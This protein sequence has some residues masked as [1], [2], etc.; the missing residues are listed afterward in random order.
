MLARCA[1]VPDVRKIA[2]LRVNALGDLIFSLPALEALR[3]AY[4]MAEIVLLA[5]DWHATFLTGRP[6]PVDRVVVVPPSTGV[7]GPPGIEVEEDP[8]ELE[9]FFAAMN[10]ERFDLAIQIHGGG[11]YSNPFVQRLGAKLA[12]GLRTPDAAPLDRWVPYIYYQSEILRYL[13]VVAL[14]GATPTILEPQLMVTEHDL[15]EAQQVVSQTRQPL[16]AL[17]PGVGD[18]RRQWP[19]EKF[20]AVGD[21]LAAA[22]AHVVVTGTESEQQLVEAVVDTMEAEAHNLCGQLS[23]GGLAGLL[24]RCRLVVSN[25][26]GPLHLAGAVGA[27]TVGIYWCGNM[28]NA[29]PITRS[30]HRPAISWRLDCPIC[31]TDCTR[32]T[33]DHRAS[34]VADVPVEEVVAA[35]HDLLDSTPWSPR[36]W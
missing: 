23:L 28:I 30:R 21:A 11:R 7:N 6:G 2:V 34:F 12:V 36:E 8:A 19:P 5:K 17:H 9:R 20:A 16:I 15:T 31:G 14:I 29:G 26:S 22:G 35:A 18:P 13:E 1:K 3:A 25:D 32:A 33:C 27:A 4:P 10:R 24:S